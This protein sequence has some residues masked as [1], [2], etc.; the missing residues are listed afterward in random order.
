MVKNVSLDSGN[1][2]RSTIFKVFLRLP[3]D[4]FS[5]KQM[6][7]AFVVI[8]ERHKMW[9]SCE[10]LHCLVVADVF[11]SAS[12]KQLLSLSIYL[13]IIFKIDCFV[14]KTSDNVEKCPLQSARG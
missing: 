4:Y 8:H 11:L 14:Y 10:P 3:S 6:L 5:E 1:T 2:F 13:P 9:T 12:D 7:S